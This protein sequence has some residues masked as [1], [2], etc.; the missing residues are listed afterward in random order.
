[1]VAPPTFCTTSG[2]SFEENIKGILISK[3]LSGIIRTSKSV[4][5]NSSSFKTHFS[6]LI[7]VDF[8]ACLFPP[9]VTDMENFNFSSTFVA[10]PV[11]LSVT[12]PP[13]PLLQPET[14]LI[15]KT[16]SPSLPHT[17]FIVTTL[18]SEEF[19]SNA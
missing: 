15:A 10:C 12:S 18:Y 17:C 14:T 5:V 13:L 2:M 7:S 19:T 16:P 8:S 6:L 4:F 1:M 3:S 11:F 9:V